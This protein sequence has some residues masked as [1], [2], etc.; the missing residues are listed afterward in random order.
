VF[1]EL[2]AGFLVCDK[3]HPHEMCTG[4]HAPI[5]IT[6]SDSQHVVAAVARE[7]RRPDFR[8]PFSFNSVEVRHGADERGAART[9]HATLNDANVLL[10]CP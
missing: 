4:L 10:V 1:A 8:E 9:A 2:V 6:N 7:Q 5:V 3:V